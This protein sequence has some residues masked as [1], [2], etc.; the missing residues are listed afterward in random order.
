MKRKLLA[1]LIAVLILTSVIWLPA[2]VLAVTN[3]FDKFDYY[4]KALEYGLKA[5]VKYFEFILKLF[6]KAVTT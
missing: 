3:N 5:L 2:L 1:I 4:I 6:E